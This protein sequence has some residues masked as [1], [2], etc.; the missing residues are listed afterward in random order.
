MGTPE[1]LFTTVRVADVDDR[2]LTAAEQHRSLTFV[3]NVLRFARHR[4]RERNPRHV[5]SP[6]DFPAATALR[7]QWVNWV[8]E[9]ICPTGFVTIL[10]PHAVVEDEQRTSA[11]PRDPLFY[12]R[13]LTKCAEDILWSKSARHLRKQDDRCLWI[14][15]RELNIEPDATGTLTSKFLHFHFLLRL[16]TRPMKGEHDPDFYRP[17]TD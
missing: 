15:T 4:Q 12:I 3:Q 8:D 2:L 13:L 16:P 14:G 11:V 6:A 17:P 1:P 7:R 9:T 5:S 10:M